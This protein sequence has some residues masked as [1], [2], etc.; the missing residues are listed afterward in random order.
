M[1]ASVT[2][3]DAQAEIDRRFAEAVAQVTPEAI[4]S[5][6]HGERHEKQIEILKCT[7]QNMIFMCSRR[8][9]KSEV[10]CGLLLLTA[11][12]TADVSCLYLALTADAA[13]PIWRKWRK[14]LRKFPMLVH[15]SSDSDQYTVFGNGSRVYFTG[16][17]DLRRVSHFLG[18]QMAGGMA[19]IDESQDD[20]GL[21]EKTVEDTL[22]PQLDE[23]TIEKPI[24]G[25]LVL[26]G[27]IPDVA[28]GYYWRTWDVHY[29]SENYR[30][31][32]IEEKRQRLGDDDDETPDDLWAAFNWSRFDNPFQVDNHKREKAYCAKYRLKPDDP[33]VLRRFRGKIVFERD[34]TAYRFDARK[35]TYRPANVETIA[36][37]PFTCTFAELVPGC[38]RFI[39]G[40]DQAQR[41]DRFT[42][43]GWAW[44]HLLRDRL[45]QFFEAGT[46]PGADPQESEWL[47]ICAT[48][49]TRYPDGS[50]EFIRDAGGSSAP[51]N[52]QLA[53]THGIT[54]SSAIKTPGSLKAGVQRL[55]DLMAVDVAKIMEGSQLAED[56]LTVRWSVKAREAGR[57]ELDKSVRSPDFCDAARYPLDLPSYTQIGGMKPPPP[58]LTEQ[59]YLA[60]EQ[61]KTLDNL[62]R[63]KGPRPPPVPN[64]VKLWLP[65]PK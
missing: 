41:R 21:M 37:G 26:S 7:A 25:R 10:C 19:I 50:M 15:K 20:P 5:G 56:M 39:V 30:Q 33:R 52:D 49:R 42:F 44:N 32:T 2:Q 36:I 1:P 3:T 18:D 4:A 13:E 48:L 62:L 12:K 61:K 47:A 45:W 60:Q 46:Q 22:G 16:T 64:F 14:L 54:I 29:D 8:A 59:E 53:F 65:P 6:K 58:R 40:I 43:V 51:V 55:S 31:R 34:A 63:G 27:T 17:D 57:W 35:H 24:P 38:D 28:A 9:G 11:I 23:T